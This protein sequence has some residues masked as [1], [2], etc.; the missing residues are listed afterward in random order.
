MK[1]GKW[2]EEKSSLD[3][4]EYIGI[5]EKILEEQEQKIAALSNDPTIFQNNS[6]AIY[7]FLKHCKVELLPDEFVFFVLKTAGFKYSSMQT[8]ISKLPKSDSSMQ[9]KVE[10]AKSKL[11]QNR[12]RLDRKNGNR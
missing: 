9:R 3:V 1:N 10:Q 4:I 12:F 8:I 11:T 6:E 5:L 7:K 2:W